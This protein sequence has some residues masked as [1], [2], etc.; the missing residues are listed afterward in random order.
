MFSHTARFPPEA[1]IEINKALSEADVQAPTPPVSCASVLAQQMGASEMQMVMAARF[2]GGI[3]L[4]GGACGALGAAV[5]LTSMESI[6]GGASKI[7]YNNPWVLEA[8]DR[9]VNSS[10]YEFESSE[11]VGPRFEDVSDH[12][13]YLREGGC[14]QIIK[15]FEN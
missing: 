13:A 11:I 7:D 8:I 15:A 10:D 6:E 14:S 1:I 2:A 12:A 9:F 5:W 3:G 4:S